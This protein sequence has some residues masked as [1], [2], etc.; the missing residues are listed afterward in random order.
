MLALFHA[1]TGL[2]LRVLASPMCTHDMRHAATMHAELSEGDTSVRQVLAQLKGCGHGRISRIV[3]EFMAR[4]SASHTGRLQHDG[5]RGRAADP[6]TRAELG[7]RAAGGHLRSGAYP[8][9][10]FRHTVANAGCRE[11]TRQNPPDE[12][13]VPVG[14]HHALV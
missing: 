11:R 4:K 9:R 3:G 10:E 14:E 13:V 6:R 7:D 12:V 1:G 2:L 8:D 5:R